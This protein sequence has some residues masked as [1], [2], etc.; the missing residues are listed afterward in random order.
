ME[1]ESSVTQS[2]IDELHSPNIQGDEMEGE[3]GFTGYIIDEIHSWD[4]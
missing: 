1:G 2:V 3:S 4:M